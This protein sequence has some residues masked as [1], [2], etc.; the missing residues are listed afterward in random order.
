MTYVLDEIETGRL[1]LDQ[2]LTATL[3]GE[4]DVPSETLQYLF[5]QDGM[6]RIIEYQGV[7]GS[8]KEGHD[9]VDVSGNSESYPAFGEYDALI[10]VE[11]G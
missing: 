10:R 6:V 4:T 8:T 1:F 7:G 9:R 2:V 5:S 11:R 3:V